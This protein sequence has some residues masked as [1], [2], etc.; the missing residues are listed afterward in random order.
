MIVDLSKLD[1]REKPLLLLQTMSGKTIAPISVAMNISAEILYNEVSKLKFTVPKQHDGVETEYYNDITSLRIVDWHNIGRF[2]IV[3][4]VITDSGIR[5]TKEVTAYSLEYE[6]TFKKITL[7]ESTYNF[8]NPVTPDSTVLGIIMSYMPSWSVGEVDNSLVGKY[9]TFDA[10]ED[11]IYDF[12]KSTLQTTYSCIFEFDTYQNLVYVRD[13]SKTAEQKPIY[14]STDNLVKELVIE[15]KSDD[16][17]TVLDVSGAEGVDIRAVN[18]L[19]TNK[20]YNLDYYMTE[21]NFS[22]DMISKWYSWKGNFNYLQQP[23]Y[24]LVTQRNLLIASYETEL[25][26]LADIKGEYSK[27]DNQRAVT[28]QAIA[29]RL[30]S[31]AALNA[32]NARLNSI[33]GQINSQQNRIEI[34]KNDI[35]DVTSRI[36]EINRRCSF[37]SFFTESEYEQL[38]KYFIEDAV[39]DS[40]FVASTVPSY[41]KKG[42]YTKVTDS[43]TIGFTFMNGETSVNRLTRNRVL[44]TITGGDVVINKIENGISTNIIQAGVVNGVLYAVTGNELA[45][46]HLLTVSLYLS[47]GIQNGTAFNTG[48]FTSSGNIW[49]MTIGSNLTATFQDGGYTFTEDVTEFDRT[50][51]EWELYQFGKDILQRKSGVTYSFDLDMEDFLSLDAFRKFKDEIEL[52]KRVYL[53]VAQGVIKPVVVGIDI[54]YD[55]IETIK[56]QFGSSFDINNSTYDLIDLTREAVNMGRK[57]DFSKY[58]FNQFI[59][60]GAS[61]SVNEFMNSALDAAV[62][63]IISSSGQAFSVDG[64]GIRLRQW[65]NEEE[66]TYEDEQIWM[67]NNSIMFTKDNWSTASIGIGKFVD[68][69]LGSLYGIVAPNIVGTLIAGENLVIESQKKSGD[70]QVFKVDADGVTLYNGDIDVNY[71]DAQITISPTIGIAVGKYD[72]KNQDGTLNENNAQFWVDT[73]GNVHM[74]GHLEAA[75]GTFSGELRAATG[76]FKGSM[77]AGSIN[78]NNQFMVDS[79]GNVTANSGTFKGTIYGANLRDSND[80]LMMNNDGQFSSDYLSLKGIEVTNNSGQTTFAVSNS[81]EITVNGNVSMSAGSTINWANVNEQNTQWNEAYQVSTNALNKANTANTNA[82]TANNNATT[83]KQNAAAAQLAADYAKGQSETVANAIKQIVNGTYQGG[84]FISGNVLYSPRLMGNSIFGNTIQFGMNGTYGYL[85]PGTGSSGSIVELYGTQ[86]V[87]I[88]SGGYVTL[89]P[90][91]GGHISLS[92][93]AYQVDVMYNGNWHSLGELFNKVGIQ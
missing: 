9:R 32:I 65:K 72:L 18:P 39:Q 15:E 81:G 75:T 30:E 22:E 92:C 76:T 50:S 17:V 63:A 40:T 5:E 85:Q 14:L 47:N 24:K 58:S 20:I 53:K 8:W 66:G 83:A 74:K 38:S 64:T 56:I 57:V 73:D 86:S 71:G 82:T 37:D 52:G 4:P 90:G 41:T 77:T 93:N 79:S 78:I 21:T 43:Q 29:Q 3:E 69:N 34:I 91:S 49:S 6:F 25:A 16:I 28:I 13:A 26:A 80:Q 12:M 88:G 27:Y 31:Q 48:N 44:Y 62:N 67:N 7:E 61:T 2:I 23:Y 42:A 60:S 51:V 1:L 55:A 89:Q 19:G 33:Q 54:D 87:R 68:D 46:E 11:N 84:T 59:D 70:R 45:P 36:K 35:D 10:N